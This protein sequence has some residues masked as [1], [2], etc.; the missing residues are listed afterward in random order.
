MLRERKKTKKNLNQYQ[1]NIRLN[2]ALDEIKTKK[3][4][5]KLEE[6]IKNQQKN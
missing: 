5:I 1:I 6:K 2:L 3:L 4:I